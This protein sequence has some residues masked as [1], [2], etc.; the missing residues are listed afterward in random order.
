[1]TVLKR[2]ISA[3][4][5]VAESRIYYVDTVEKMVDECLAGYGSRRCSHRARG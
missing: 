4:E 3:G 1:V 2:L 5:V